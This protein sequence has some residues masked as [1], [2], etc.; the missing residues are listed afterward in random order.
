MMNKHQKCMW[1]CTLRKFLTPNG[2]P[3]GRPPKRHPKTPSAVS[4]LH[5]LPNSPRLLCTPF[6]I[7]SMTLP[8]LTLYPPLLQCALLRKLFRT[9]LRGVMGLPTWELWGVLQEAS[10]KST[11]KNSIGWLFIKLSSKLSWTPLYSPSS[12]PNNSPQSPFT[13]PSNIPQNSL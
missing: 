12:T 8:F 9:L 11:P 5:P 7:R 1:G 13:P 4:P 6:R 10:T 3:R 2:T